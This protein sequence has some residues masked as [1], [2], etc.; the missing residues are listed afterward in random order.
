MPQDFTQDNRLIAVQTPRGKDAF[1]LTGI[2][3]HEAVSQ[4]FEFDLEMLSDEVT[5][6]EKTLVGENV[7]F[8]IQ[9]RGGERA[10]FNGFISNFFAA[11]PADSGGRVYHARVVPWMWF[12]TR[13]ANSRIFQKKNVV[14]IV[15]QIFSDHGFSDFEFRTQKS[16][17]EYE[18]KV[19]YRETDFNFVSRLLEHEGIF[20][21]FK[22]ENGKHTA[23]FG[24]APSVFSPS[25]QDKVS[26]VPRPEWEHLHGWHH[27]YEFRPGKWTLTD[28]DFKK[29]QTDLT[30]D[31]PTVAGPPRMKQY[32]FFDYPGLYTEKDAGS[33]LA[34]TRIESEEADYHT[35]RGRG[36]VPSFHAG[37]TFTLEHHKISDEEGKE[38]ALLSVEHHAVETSYSRADAG[39]SHYS[40]S[41]VALPSKTVFRPPRNTP[42][43]VMHGPQTATVVGPKGEEIYTDEYGRVKVQFRWDR[44]GKADEN[45]SVFLRVAQNWSGKLWGGQIVPRIGMEAIVE[46]LEGDPDKPIVTGCFYNATAM[47]AD[48]LPDN[49]TRTVFRTRST[50]NASGFNE[51]SF[52]DKAGSEQVFLHGERDEDIRIKNDAK[53]WIGHD[54][55]LIVKNDQFEKV[56]GSKNLHVIGDQKEK[57][58]GSVSLDAAEDLH[59]K[60]G[61]NAALKAGMNVAIEAGIQIT[62]KAG[63]NFID[64]SPAGI[65]IVGTPVVMINSGGAPGPLTAMPQAP[66]EAKEADDRKPGQA[67]PAAITGKKPDP[68]T[69]PT[70]VSESFSGGDSPQAQTLKQA[71]QTGAPFCAI[72]A[73]AAAAGA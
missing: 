43:P 72:C 15:K 51:F 26:F 21:F 23:I 28:Y 22:H 5:V 4:L 6:D 19:Q 73:A 3:G 48:A 62:L 34:R 12:L 2:S 13:A 54:R 69:A 63:P 30:A 53:E 9:P 25:E 31:Q 60:L 24:D 44:Y 55:H 46:F 58:G 49:K 16:Y 50:P 40:N 45:S 39:P 10:F 61:M 64:I 37:E 33:A 18:Y 56:E 29:P 38:Y 20:Y 57:V 71:A 66:T 65:L 11:E 70:L 27:T 1:L 52:E 42:V 35:V 7:T 14:D 8:S 67:L 32:E 36:M 59:Q 47:P 17:K 68:G 41:F